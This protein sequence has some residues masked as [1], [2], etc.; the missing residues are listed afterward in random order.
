[1]DFI[2]LAMLYQNLTYNSS[3]NVFCN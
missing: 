1:M 2:E 3:S